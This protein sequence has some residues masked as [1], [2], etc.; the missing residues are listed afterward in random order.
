LSG[1][2]TKVEPVQRRFRAYWPDE[3]EWHWLELDD[4]GYAARHVVL[5]CGEPIVAARLDEMIALRD[6]AG[7][8][9]VQL[10]EAVYGVPAEGIVEVPAGAILVEADEFDHVFRKAVNQRNFAQTTT[11]PFPHGSLVQ[12]TFGTNPWPSGVTGTYVDIGHGPVHGFVD[13]RWFFQN[14]ASWPDPGTEAQ[15]RV[16]DLRFHSL[17]LRLQPTSATRP[18]LTWPQPY[19]WP[20]R[21]FRR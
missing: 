2:R 6:R 5:R 7:L 1:F 14:H 21:E 10:Y 11:G 20:K 17:Q 8:L 19:D 18:G 12:G 16:I 4:Q 15:F 13:A 3:D 9:G